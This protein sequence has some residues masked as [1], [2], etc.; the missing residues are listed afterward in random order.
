MV[1][2]SALRLTGNRWI[3]VALLTAALLPSAWLAWTWRAMPQTGIFHD[4]ALYL[5]AAKSLAEGN[6]YRIASL[7]GQ[8]YQT[9]YPPL[10]PALLSL[11]WRIDPS[12]PGNLPKVMLLTWA[13]LAGAAFLTRRLMRQ[14]GFS[15][16]ESLGLAVFVA[17]SP[18][19]VQFSVMAMSE[20]PF[21]ALLLV[22]LIL[23]ERGYAGWAGLFGG[24]AFLTRGAALPL[25]FT[26]P[27]VFL[28]RRQFR[29][30]AQFAAAMA[31]AVVIWQLWA[32]WHRAPADPLTLFYTDYFGYHR[33]DVPFAEWTEMLVFNLNPV[34]K[35]IGEL[36]IFDED[37]GFGALTLARVLTVASI[38]GCIRLMRTGRMVHYSCFGALYLV[39]FLFW[40]F[41]PTHRFFLPLLPLVAAGAYREFQSL[42]GIIRA[43]FAKKTADRVVA[44]AMCAFLAYLGI[45]SLRYS[46]WGLFRFLPPVFAQRGQ[47]LAQQHEAHRWISAHAS[48]GAALLSYQ[49]PVDYLYT[50]R[51]GY[52]LRVPPSVL[53]RGDQREI[54]RFFGE[55]PAMMA[56]H[57]IDHVVL[58]QADYHMDCPDLTVKAYRS[59]FKNEKLFEPVLQRGA[60]AVYRVRRAHTAYDSAR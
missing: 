29:Q 52:S 50:G 25:L 18:V 42:S 7:P 58:G 59:I 47:L 23:A 46:A 32:A 44:V 38:S 34:V 57:G 48:P 30:A 56:S 2:Q 49:D 43:A 8:P 20:V 24:L 4:D 26:A 5:V 55:L 13:F 12:F 60:T 41:P 14:C 16:G 31:P 21:L 33:R 15:A 39:Q 3:A 54:E 53:K 9:K 35:A 6:G 10:Y 17:L 27:M 11:V 1:A 36:L 51:R 37:S 22:S 45:E 40:N 19:A 28:W